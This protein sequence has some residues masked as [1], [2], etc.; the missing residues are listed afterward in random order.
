MYITYIILC[1]IYI[2]LLHIYI[3][4]QASQKFIQ[5]GKNEAISETNMQKN[6]CDVR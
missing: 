6:N 2:I 1:I 3:S 5:Q 4:F